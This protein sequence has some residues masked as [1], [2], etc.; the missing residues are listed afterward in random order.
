MLHLTI[1]GES[2]DEIMTKLR[3]LAASEAP[4]GGETAQKAEPA[5]RTRKAKAAPEPQEDDGDEIDEKAEKV[6]RAVGDAGIVSKPPKAKAPEPE[7]EDDDA[8]QGEEDV[9]VGVIREVLVEIKKHPNGGAAAV[10]SVLKPYGASALAEVEEEHYRDLFSDAKAFL[11][12]IEK[13]R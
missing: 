4:A 9:P 6:R 7:A 10:Q 13:K 3:E 2:I 5:K 12:K 1:V 11:S 8:D